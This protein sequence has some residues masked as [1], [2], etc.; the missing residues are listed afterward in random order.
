MVAP[1]CGVYVRGNKQLERCTALEGTKRRR[2][3]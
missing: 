1:A 3:R 2:R